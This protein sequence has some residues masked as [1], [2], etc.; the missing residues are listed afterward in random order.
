MIKL[1]KYFIQSLFVYFFFIIG[2]L[3]G[4]SQSRRVFSFLFKK[5][6][7]NFKSQKI[8]EKNL[9]IFNSS[10]SPEEKRNIVENMWS[11]YGMTFIEYIYLSKFRN[12]NNFKS[13]K[14]NN[15]RN[16]STFNL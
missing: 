16:G 1:A 5:V 13:F 9:N 3:I 12:S 10:L 11:N 6:G 4:L 8:I 15:H 2:R 14:R 7:Q